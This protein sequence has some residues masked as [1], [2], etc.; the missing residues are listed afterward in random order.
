M[1]AEEA[2]PAGDQNA[3]IN[4]TFRAKESG[5]ASAENAP[6]GNASPAFIAQFSH[7]APWATPDLLREH[8]GPN[9]QQH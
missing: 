3:H 4:L 2:R 9:W 5:L 6:D 1:G 8:I 7:A